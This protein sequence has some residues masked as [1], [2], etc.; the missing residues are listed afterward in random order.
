MPNYRRARIT[1]GT[2]FFTVVT[3][4]R[5][6]LLASAPAV[7]ALQD[8][9]AGVT[10][11]HPFTM[12]A[13]VILPDH[14]H[15]IWTLPQDDGDFSA[16]WRLVKTRFSRACR[17]SKR[18]PI[19]PP[20]LLKGDESPWQERFWEH[21]IRDEMDFNTHCDYI[22]YNPVKHGL[23]ESPIKWPHSTFEAFVRRGFYP[24]DWG[25]S[26]SPQVMAMDLE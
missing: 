23:V 15:C 21:L 6:P 10:A 26:V 9:F 14:L 5:L 25:R 1:G 19:L 16:R 20:S 3:R 24:A 4:H 22:H 11:H 12:D 2:Y 18:G 17:I 13:L 8:S 7:S